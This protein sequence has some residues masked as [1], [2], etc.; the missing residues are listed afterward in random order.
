[1]IPSWLYASCSTRSVSGSLLDAPLFGRRG[2][3]ESESQMAILRQVAA[4]ARGS[5]AASRS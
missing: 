5:E 1:M 2:N 4:T 3:P